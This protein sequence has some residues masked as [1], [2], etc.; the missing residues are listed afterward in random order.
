MRSEVIFTCTIRGSQT[1]T[2]L[3]LTWS[4]TEYIGQG[5]ALQFTSESMLGANRSSMI[6]GN[7]TAILTNSIMIDGVPVLVSMLHIVGAS[8]TSVITCSSNSGASERITFF[9]SGTY[10]RVQ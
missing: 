3:I 7:V 10:V 5:G 9:G 4:S 8:Q 6:N 2:D 1:F